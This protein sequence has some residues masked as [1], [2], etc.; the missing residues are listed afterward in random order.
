M[1]STYLSA[2][3][4][5]GFEGIT[6]FPTVVLLEGRYR[7]FLEASGYGF[8]RELALLRGRRERGLATLCYAHTREEAR[9]ASAAGADIINI[10]LGWNTGGALGVSTRMRIEEAADLAQSIVQMVRRRAP[11]HVLRHRGGADRQ[12]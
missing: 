4:A 10:D 8:A 6:N 5:A 11:G 9:R 7:R 12:P 1:S 2:I 3:A